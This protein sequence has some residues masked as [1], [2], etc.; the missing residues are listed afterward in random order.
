M[1]LHA[2]PLG[3]A[4]LWWNQAAKA[5][6]KKGA[7]HERAARRGAGVALSWRKHTRQFST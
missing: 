1:A 7:Q 4:A 5:Q 2:L 3:P 6:S